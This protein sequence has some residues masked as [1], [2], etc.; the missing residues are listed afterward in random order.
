VGNIQTYRKVPH[1]AADWFSPDE[2]A[3][4]KRYQKPLTWVGTIQ[5]LVNLGV[6]LAVIGTHLFPR[7][8]DE[9]GV[10]A[11]PLR[12]LL[13]LVGLLLIF[14]V[15]DLP[16][17]LWFTFK[18]EKQWGFSTQ[19]PGGWA[20]DQV[21]GFFV[22]ILVQGVLLF[23][24]WAL[25]RATDLW[26]IFGWAVF[27][28]FSMLFTFLYPVLIMPIFNKF[29]PLDDE[30]L[31]TKLRGLAEGA[32]MQVKG[33][34]VM[35]A[36]KRTKKDNAFFAGL[37]ASRRI[38]LFDNLLQQPHEAIES[39]VAHELGHW[40]LRHLR[41]GIALGLVT[42]F[43]LFLVLRAVSTW[44]PALDFAGV[45]SIRDPAALP[46]VALVFLAGSSVVGFV[47]SWFSRAMER[48]ADLFALRTTGDPIA[49]TAM[50]RGL[51]T[52][53]LS[54][55][56]PSWWGYLKLSHPPAAER[57]QFAKSWEDEREPVR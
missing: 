54:D 44:E 18:H 1:D 25:I 56:A 31:E 23:A 17:D 24:L 3:K 55:L 40:K 19:T 20:G 51:A 12:L 8:L 32:G 22:G 16:R 34:Q 42:S 38:V 5:T 28:L 57:L 33:T 52:R 41:R 35:D 10:T 39:V 37:G 45:D 47:S 14:F 36:S 29:T 30:A 6:L 2:V 26:W 7:L 21:K 53:N 46:L 11:W 27:F 48:Q 49:F 13:T 9:L 43:L 15:V 50:M 4:A